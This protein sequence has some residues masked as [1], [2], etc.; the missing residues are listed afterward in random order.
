MDR[1]FS[2]VCF[3][4]TRG[5]GFKIK[6]GGFRLDI[7]KKVFYSQGDETL[8]QAAQRGDGRPVPGDFQGEAESG[9]QQCDL[10]VVSLIIAGELE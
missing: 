3:N 7:R 6:K 1:L 8:E 10:D 2:C 4:R 5:S 9:P